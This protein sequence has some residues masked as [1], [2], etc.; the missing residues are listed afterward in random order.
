M[1]YGMYRYAGKDGGVYAEP[2]KSRVAILVCRRCAIS[3]NLASSFSCI[4]VHWYA[5]IHGKS[6]LIFFAISFAHT[7]ISGKCVLETCYA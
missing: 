5:F 3:R 4:S 2:R 6:V 1:T 7:R